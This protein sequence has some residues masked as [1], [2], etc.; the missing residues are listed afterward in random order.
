MWDQ[1]NLI[2]SKMDAATDSHW[3]VLRLCEVVEI[4][5]GKSEATIWDVG[6]IA[7]IWKPWFEYTSGYKFLAYRYE[8]AHEIGWWLHQQ[9]KEQYHSDTKD[10]AE[11]ADFTGNR[12][13]VR[14]VTNTEEIVLK[15]IAT[16]V[17]DDPS[18][19]HLFEQLDGGGKSRVEEF[20]PSPIAGIDHHPAKFSPHTGHLLGE[21]DFGALDFKGWLSQAR[22][23]GRDSKILKRAETA[24]LELTGAP[25]RG[26]LLFGR[27]IESKVF[28]FCLAGQN[29]YL[30]SARLIRARGID[31]PLWMIADSH[32]FPFEVTEFFNMNPDDLMEEDATPFSDL[33]GSRILDEEEIET[34]SLCWLEFLRNH[35][36]QQF[37]KE[38]WKRHWVTLPTA[39]DVYD[40]WSSSP[41]YRARLDRTPRYGDAAGFQ[42][43]DDT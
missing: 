30:M 34:A 17:R 32:D 38:T 10:G 28:D 22:E 29:A 2:P 6:P 36:V 26:A 25:N 12:N 33:N 16:S 3:A 41:D 13:A 42:P 43:G 15:K 14:A 18:G 35:I 23:W 19:N 40:F 7:A 11:T 31:Y 21:K 5:G 1:L 8:L 9:E 24:Y 37:P 39:Q 4:F 20:L 27:P